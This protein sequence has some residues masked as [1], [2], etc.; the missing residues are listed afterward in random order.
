MSRTLQLA[1]Q[2]IA[3]SSVTPADA[4]CLELIAAR[5]TPLGFVCERMDSGPA[6]FRVHNLWAIR[7]GNGPEAQTLVFAGHTDVV[8][9]GPLDHWTTDPFIPA[10]R[11]RKSTRLNSSHIPLSR[12]PSS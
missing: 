4:G 1:E 10:I 11:D 9:P 3:R 7:R 12:M 5:L 2:L 6:S 8:P